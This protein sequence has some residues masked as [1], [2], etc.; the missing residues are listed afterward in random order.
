MDRNKALPQADLPHQAF[1]TD[2]PPDERSTLSPFQV[3]KVALATT[4]FG[5]GAVLFVVGVI[6]VTQVIVRASP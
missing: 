1:I 6:R 3:A 2:G 4:L 5:T